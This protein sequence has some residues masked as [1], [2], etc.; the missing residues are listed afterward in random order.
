M[1]RARQILREEMNQPGT[2]TQ[3]KKKITAQKE[4]K[5][6]KSTHPKVKLIKQSVAKA[7]KRRT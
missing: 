7:K 2:M 5:T 3:Q 1:G 4:T 6:K